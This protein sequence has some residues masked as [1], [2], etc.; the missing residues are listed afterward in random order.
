MLRKILPLMVLLIL[1]WSDSALGWR[2]GRH[3]RRV[4]CCC[5]TEAPES[6][7]AGPNHAQSKTLLSGPNY[8]LQDIYLDF[9]DGDD[10]FECN[11]YPGGCR[12][13]PSPY[14]D[15]FYGTP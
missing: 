12:N 6:A 11:V 15:L 9:D 14:E 3:C 1:V 5:P 2:L 7:E 8:C 4:K 10:L 13:A